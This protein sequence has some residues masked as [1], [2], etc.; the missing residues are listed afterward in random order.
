[1]YKKKKQ[2]RNSLPTSLLKTLFNERVWFFL[3][4]GLC[5]KL[6]W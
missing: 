6:N 3:M 1:M 5:K 2:E 4:R